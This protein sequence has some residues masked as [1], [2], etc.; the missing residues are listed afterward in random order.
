VIATTLGV[1]AKHVALALA[2]APT[3]H[4]LVHAVS[5]SAVCHRQQARVK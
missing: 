3:V 5:I 1:L 4:E 2:P